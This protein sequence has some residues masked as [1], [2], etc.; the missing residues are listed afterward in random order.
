MKFTIKKIGHS[1]V[2]YERDGVKILID[3]GDW[4]DGAENETSIRHIFIT[5]KHPDHLH[6]PTLQALIERNPGAKVW[7]N[8]DVGSELTKNVI[9]WN[10]FEEGQQEFGGIQ[11]EAIGQYHARIHRDQALIGNTGLL[12]DDGTFFHPGDSH[13]LPGKPVKVLA[14]PF[15]APWCTIEQAVDFAIGVSPKHCFGIHDGFLREEA[16]RF[17]NLPKCFLEQARIDYFVLANGEGRTFEI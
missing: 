14:L 15:M 9:A 2:T 1:C 17:Q 13:L 12:F 11:I 10:L 8:S 16:V 6:V 4:S 7:T 5:H 3:P